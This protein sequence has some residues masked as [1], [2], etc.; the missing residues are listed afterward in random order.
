MHEHAVVK[1]GADMPLDVAALLG[2][3]VMTG[4]GAGATPLASSPAPP[5][6]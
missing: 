6:P 2:C 4:V 1:I 5:S 3:G